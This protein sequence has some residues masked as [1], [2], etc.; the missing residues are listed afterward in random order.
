MKG[1]PLPE[2]G[3]GIAGA[4]CAAASTVA[5]YPLSLIV[6]R[7]QLKNRPA[8]VRT[9]GGNKVKLEQHDEDVQSRNVSGWVQIVHVAKGIHANG[10]LRAFYVGVVEAAGKAAA[11]VLLF[12]LVYKSLQ[13]Q[14]EVHRSKNAPGLSVAGKLTLGLASEAITK[15]VIAPI[16][17]IVTRKQDSREPVGVKDLVTQV[18]REQGATGLWAGYSASLLMTVMPADCTL[19]WNAELS[20]SPERGS[21]LGQLP[22][23]LPA[24]LS[25]IVAMSFT[26]PLSV[27][28]VRMQAGYRRVQAAD[29]PL[30][31]SREPIFSLSLLHTLS[32]FAKTEGTSAIY[33]GITACIAQSLLSRGTA[34]LTKGPIYT[35]TVRA[36]YIYLL[37]S[38]QYQALLDRAKKEIE[39]LAVAAGEQAKYAQELKERSIRDMYSNETAD[40]VGDYVEDE[41]TECKRFYHW[42]F[43]REKRGNGE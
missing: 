9:R 34:T 42:F 40:L 8:E 14:L 26:Y 18:L 22:R 10:G 13:R 3:R 2:L 17:T 36:Y 31:G 39:G 24:I 35:W 4:L 6:T 33:A 23:S 12:F 43:E 38:S 19:G 25:R 11:D 29:S 32:H 16:E 30:A 21:L 41:A 20:R 7:L 27:A 5:V 1:P 28:R 37:L 15:L